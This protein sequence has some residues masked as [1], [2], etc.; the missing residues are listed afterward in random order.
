MHLLFIYD[1]QKCQNGTI[2]DTDM[3]FSLADSIYQIT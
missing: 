2:P 1:E 3:V